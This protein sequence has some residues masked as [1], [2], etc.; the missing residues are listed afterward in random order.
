MRPGSCLERIVIMSKGINESTDSTLTETEA[1]RQHLA[2]DV[3]LLLAIH[4]L[5]RTCGSDACVGSGD[6]SPANYRPDPGSG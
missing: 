2:N 3:G 6:A 4:W 5:E 1:A